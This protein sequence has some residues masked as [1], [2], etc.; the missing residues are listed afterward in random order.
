VNRQLK[1]ASVLRGANVDSLKLVLGR[2]FALDKLADLAVDLAQ[3]LRDVAGNILIYLENLQRGLGDL[4]FGLRRGR[5]QLATFAVEPGRLAFKCREPVELNQILVPKVTHACQL[6][7]HERNF[8]CLRILL[9]GKA[10]NFLAKL[11]DPLL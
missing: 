10:G 11:G 7:L 5:D 8:F 3:L 4:A 6:S 1:N 9:G 2:D